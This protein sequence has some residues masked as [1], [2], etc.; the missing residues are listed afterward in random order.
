MPDENGRIQLL[1]TIGVANVGFSPD[2]KYVILGSFAE[3]CIGNITTKG[4]IQLPKRIGL[5]A[6]VFIFLDDSKF[7]ATSGYR[8]VV[9][10]G[11]KD[12]GHCVQ[13]FDG[14]KDKRPLAFSPD[15]QWPLTNQ[16][17]PYRWYMRRIS[18]NRPIRTELCTRQSRVSPSPS[19][20]NEKTG[21]QLVTKFSILNRGE[22]DEFK[23]TTHV[24]WGP[25]P[26][27]VK[28]V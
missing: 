4:P 2:G 9:G 28:E 8:G 22:L 12:S 7:F 19:S 1:D 3:L 13:K 27:K 11:D 10:V 16:N 26:L 21:F 20:S 17:R 14:S 6:E 5:G 25:P 24:G 15:P 23:H 18:T